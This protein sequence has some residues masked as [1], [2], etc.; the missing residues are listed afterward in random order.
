MPISDRKPRGLLLLAFRLPVW[1]YRLHLGWLLGDRFLLLTHL[2][3]KSG[4]PHQTVLEVIGHDK[5]TDAYFVIAAFGERSDWLLNI[6]QHPEVTITIRGRQRTVQARQVPEGD[7]AQI[8]LDYA[9]RHPIAF[10]EISVL[11]TG[12]SMDPSKENCGQL[13]QSRPVVAFEPQNR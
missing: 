2:G 4:I 12:R 6:L 3:R 8:L 9:N 5:S 11:L 7:G 10:R 1:V 13:I